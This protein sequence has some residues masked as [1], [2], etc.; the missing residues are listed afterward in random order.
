V[1]E[2]ENASERLLT[3]SRVF[4]SG[5][6]N[7]DISHIRAGRLIDGHDTKEEGVARTSCQTGGI[8]KK[9]DQKSA[10]SK[11]GASVNFD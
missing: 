11:N 5:E 9:P 7:S 6:E 10:E 3:N 8:Q 2:I 1:K 4:K